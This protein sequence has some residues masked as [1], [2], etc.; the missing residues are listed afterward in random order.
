MKLRKNFLG[1]ISV[2]AAWSFTAQANASDNPA[3]DA[4]VK[5]IN[6]EWARIKYQMV[7]RSNQYD[8][9]DALAKQA[10]QVA[11]RYPG[12]AEPLLWQGIVNSEE[13]AMASTFSKLGYASTARDI[14]EKARAINPKAAN[15][16]V[17]MSLGVLYYKVPG[18]PIGFGSAK[19]ARGYLDAALAMDPNGLDANFFYG[20]FLAAQGDYTNAKAH[21]VR[22][23]KAPAD[24]T[25]PIWDA[26]RRGEARKL[27]A[28]VDRHLRG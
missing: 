7:G 13:A 6:D 11:A 17:L 23:L 24:P 3:M 25:R 2:L 19:K 4:Q 5:H 16:G 1:A 18:F 26:G 10:A 21:L 12:R 14:L 22:A 8:E 28:E 9:I 15:G 20:D 27:M